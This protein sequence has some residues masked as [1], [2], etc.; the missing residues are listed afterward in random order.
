MPK[1]GH[2]MQNKNK[3]QIMQQMSHFGVYPCP[4]PLEESKI[5]ALKKGGGWHINDA[6]GWKML[7]TET[8]WFGSSPVSY[9]HPAAIVKWRHQNTPN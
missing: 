5:I 8:F 7:K 9:P 1:K 2:K 6:G 3:K 4:R